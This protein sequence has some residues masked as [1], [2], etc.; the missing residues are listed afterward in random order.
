MA[1]N[2]AK[3]KKKKKDCTD[4]IEDFE[5]VRLSW[6]IKVQ[7][8]LLYKKAEGDLTQTEEKKVI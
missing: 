8:H 7:S 6:I 1:L 4:M 5:M 3:K 2:I